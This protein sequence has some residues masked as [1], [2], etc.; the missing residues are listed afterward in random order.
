MGG[1][2][3]HKFDLYMSKYGSYVYCWPLFRWNGSGL[4]APSPN[5]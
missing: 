1:Q 2:L 4:L 5:P 3:L